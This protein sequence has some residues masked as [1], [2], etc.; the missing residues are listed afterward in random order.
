MAIISYVKKPENKKW[1]LDNEQTFI[2]YMATHHSLSDMVHTYLHA[3]TFND[4]YV[5]KIIQEIELTE[6][7][8]EKEEKIRKAKRNGKKVSEI[9]EMTAVE[10]KI[11]KMEEAAKDIEDQWEKDGELPD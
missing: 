3:E 5:E 9:K 1:L 10:K 11:A 7:K 4:A 2:G 6:K 8:K